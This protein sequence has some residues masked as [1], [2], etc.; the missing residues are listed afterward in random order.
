MSDRYTLDPQVTRAL[1]NSTVAKGAVEF[2]IDQGH[3]FALRPLPHNF[4][5]VT[6][7]EA[8]TAQQLDRHLASVG[9]LLGPTLFQGFDL[10]SCCGNCDDP[11]G[12]DA[13]QEGL[14]VDCY[15]KV[16]HEGR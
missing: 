10:G 16:R 15:E 7:D 6:L 14:C 2:L 11:V 3:A 4:W 13:L 9:H 8:R 5:L 1:P 12:R